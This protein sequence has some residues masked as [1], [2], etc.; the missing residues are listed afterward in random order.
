VKGLAHLIAAATEGVGG[1]E[2]AVVHR[3][4]VLLWPGLFWREEAG[5]DRRSAGNRQRP[6]LSSVFFFLPPPPS[7]SATQLYTVLHAS[8]NIES[9]REALAG[10]RGHVPGHYRPLD[11]AHG[12]LGS[13]E[14]WS[15]CKKVLDI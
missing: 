13:G 1:V 5:T 7:A 15:F 12:L 10:Q 6:S 8:S 4:V 11:R 3:D 2:E 9:A 14:L